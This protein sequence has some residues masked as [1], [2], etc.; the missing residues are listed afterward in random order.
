MIFYPIIDADGFLTGSISEAGLNLSDVQNV[1]F[2]SPPG[3]PLQP[4]QKYRWESGAWVVRTDYRGHVWY[5]PDEPDANQHR[6]STWSDAPPAGW[7]LWSPGQDRTPSAAAVLRK[8][9]ADKWSEIKSAAAAATNGGFVAGGFN[10]DSDLATQQAMQL[11]WQDMKEA[12][13]PTSVSW[14]TA[15]GVAKTLTAAQFKNLARALR[16]HLA[17][18]RDKGATLRAAIT[19][20]TTPAEVAAVSW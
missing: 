9:K 14:Y 1:V 19:A 5:D 17:A 3:I 4:L 15:E 2:V 10:W 6:P 8:A 16:T 7:L 20:A 11:T 13:G 12:D 18:Q